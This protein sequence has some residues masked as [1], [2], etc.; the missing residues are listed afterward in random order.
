MIYIYIHE[1]QNCIDPD[2]DDAMLLAYRAL[3][4]VLIYM[5]KLNMLGD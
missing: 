2:Y 3:F 5:H 1:K 4:A